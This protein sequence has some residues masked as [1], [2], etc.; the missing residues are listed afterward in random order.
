LPQKVS[1]EDAGRGLQMF[2]E[3]NVTVLGIVENM[4]YLTTPDGSK[5][6]IF[7]SGGGANMAKEF[8]VPFLGS[9][10]IDPLIRIG[11]DTWK[12]VVIDHPELEVAKTLVDISEIIAAQASIAAYESNLI[13]AEE[14]VI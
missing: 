13:R 5:M 14:E 7:G 10:P 2:R 12:P 4:S 9:I 3:L 6:D 1:Q 11:G 8:D